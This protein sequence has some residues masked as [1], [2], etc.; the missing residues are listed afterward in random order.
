[1]KK[2]TILISVL[3]LAVVFVSCTTTSVSFKGTRVGCV[4]TEGKYNFSLSCESFDGE[5]VYTINLDEEHG[6]IVG[7]DVT[8]WE[9]TL[10]LECRDSKDHLVATRSY[11]VPEY[12]TEPSAKYYDQASFYEE[13][14][15][16]KIKI[17]AKGFKGDYSF[18]WDKEEVLDRLI[19]D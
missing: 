18:N 12:S 2:L 4:R 7:W 8:V 19:Y 14:G 1:M 11:S 6:R 17:I 13:Y 3:L 5:A 16:C 15:K 10:E 9:G